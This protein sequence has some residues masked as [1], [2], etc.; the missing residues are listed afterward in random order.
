[1]FKKIFAVLLLSGALFF[2]GI[3]E[4]SLQSSLDSMFMSNAT[5]PQAYHS[6]SRGGFV[7]GGLSVRAPISNIN[8]IAFDPPRLSAGCGGIDMYGG[9]FTFINAAQMAA[10]FRQIAANAA[11]ALFKMAIDAISPEIGKI[12]QDFQSMVQNMNNMAKN[13]CQIGSAAPKVIGDAVSNQ[14]HLQNA[15]TAINAALGNVA[16]IFES[17]NSFLTKPQSKTEQ[18][19]AAGAMPFYGNLVWKALAESNAGATLGSPGTSYTQTPTAAGG[20]VNALDAAANEIVMSLLG[21]EITVQKESAVA[22]SSGVPAIPTGPNG[23]EIT[24]NGSFYPHTI[25]LWDLMDS[26]PAGSEI[27]VWRCD[28][29]IETGCQNLTLTP[30][31]DFQGMR[32][33]VNRIMF[34]QID[35]TVGVSAGS[36]IANLNTCST[37]GC[38]F[39]AEQTRFIATM[40]APLL[41]I[42][43]DIQSDSSAMGHVAQMLAPVMAIE[44]LEKY[45]VAAELAARNAFTGVKNTTMPPSIPARLQVLDEQL[46]EIRSIRLEMQTN[47]THT[48]EY[49]NLILTNEPGLYVRTPSGR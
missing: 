23:V 14:F 41:K 38:A 33:Y 6:Q 22:A 12:M 3:S 25:N 43:R 19:A 27:K 34:G 44:M 8:A 30:D 47:I 24:Q 15:A 20:T 39:T 46:R 1:M 16:D 11:G 36:L 7:G 40:S 18:A 17:I 9:S 42:L 29:H 21:T 5:P 26:K 45:G 28:D 35:D 31:T 10:L 32:G 13:T 4:A 48:K 37:S 49:A 2:A